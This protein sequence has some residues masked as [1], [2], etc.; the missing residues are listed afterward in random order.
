M[1][2]PRVTDAQVWEKGHSLV[3]GEV[4]MF[5]YVVWAMEMGHRVWIWG[6]LKEGGLWDRGDAIPVCRRNCIQSMQG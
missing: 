1:S 5:G 6:D 4:L 2:C 3:K